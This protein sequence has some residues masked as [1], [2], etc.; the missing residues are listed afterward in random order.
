L[1]HAAFAFKAS[2]EEPETIC[3]MHAQAKKA[4]YR[5]LVGSLCLVAFLAILIILAGDF[6]DT[7]A[8]I[9]GTIFA[10][11]LYS[12]TAY[13][14]SLLADRRPELALLA[15]AG[16]GASIVG[17]LTAL[18]PIWSDDG[19]SEQWRLAGTFVVIALTLADV[20]LLLVARRETDGQAVR[21]IVSLTIVAV[22]IVAV[23]LVAELSEHGTY[24]D[25]YYRFVG[26]MAVLWALG[27]LL[28]PVLRRA[29]ALSRRP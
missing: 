8:R 14:Q 22:S 4:F 19:S 26:V 3:E 29:E 9:I 11:V 12:W 25:S 20:A 17:F 18:P 24:G 23:M 5:I 28:A 27:T 1:P 6:D 7:D 15:L 10:I 21:S 13:V 16:I 2:F